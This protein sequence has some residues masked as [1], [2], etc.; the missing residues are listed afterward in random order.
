MR[1]L[2]NDGLERVWNGIRDLLKLDRFLQEKLHGESH[3]M[4]GKEFV[5]EPIDFLVFSLK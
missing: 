5:I 3:F 2:R 1:L 4:G